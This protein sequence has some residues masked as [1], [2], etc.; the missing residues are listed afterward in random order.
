VDHAAGAGRRAT[1]TVRHGQRLAQ[2]RAADLAGLRVVQAADP[3][4]RGR[5][6]RLSWGRHS[7]DA[8]DGGQWA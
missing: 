5:W 1:R 6:V 4:L 3:L 8:H 2:M 7:A